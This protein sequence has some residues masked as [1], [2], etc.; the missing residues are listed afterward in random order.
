MIL[1]V[2]IYIYIYILGYRISPAKFLALA[3]DICLIFENENQGTYYTKGRTVSSGKQVKKKIAPS[4]K[5]YDHF[6]N[7]SV[8]TVFNLD[9]VLS[10]H[11]TH[12]SH[13]N[14][15]NFIIKI[16]NKLL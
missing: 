16:G 12:H 15:N 8:Q 11:I 10:C 1:I 7:D 4:G 6:T 13:V 9:Y 2:Y 3:E 5:L 14:Y